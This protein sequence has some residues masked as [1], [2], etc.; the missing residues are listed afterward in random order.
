MRKV[1]YVYRYQQA[2][3]KFHIAKEFWVLLLSLG[4]MQEKQFYHIT[5][6]LS[7]DETTNF[8]VRGIEIAEARTGRL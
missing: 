5:N 1:R 4:N 2:F 6:L 3:N 7:S 8:K